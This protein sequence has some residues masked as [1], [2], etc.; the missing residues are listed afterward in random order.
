MIFVVV[1]IQHQYSYPEILLKDRM[2][3]FQIKK[4]TFCILL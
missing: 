3:Y 4:A 1:F 2:R